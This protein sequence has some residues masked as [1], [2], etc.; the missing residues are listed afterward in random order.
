MINYVIAAWGGTRRERFAQ[1]VPYLKQHVDQLKAIGWP[2]HV[3]IVAPIGDGAPMA[4]YDAL[5]EAEGLGAVVLRRENQGLSYGSWNYAWKEYRGS[6]FDWW[7]FIED[8]YVPMVHNFEFEMVR[9]YGRYMEPR[10][11]YLCGIVL[12][13]P[14]VR[15]AALSYGI[16]EQ[17]CLD[18]IDAKYGEL[19]HAKGDLPAQGG[20]VGFSH[21]FLETEMDIRDIGCEYRALY[22]QK[23]GIRVFF[24]EN[25][26]ELIRPLQASL[27]PERKWTLG[28]CKARQD[29]R[30]HAKITRR[31][32]R[33]PTEE[34][35]AT[36]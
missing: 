36:G 24:E 25:E 30:A 9:L 5:S 7:I 6:G 15:H 20:Q 31:D 21:C 10:G 13:V 26:K 16:T 17:R 18:R 11:G 22:V 28:G 33:T 23:G 12:G 27:V 3:T 1:R 4:Y 19:P 29:W 8:D 32:Q 2:S 34:G 35:S 14:E